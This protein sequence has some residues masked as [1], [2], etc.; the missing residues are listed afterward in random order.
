MTDTTLKIVEPNDDIAPQLIDY[1][2]FE[3][4]FFLLDDDK[5]SEE[6]VDY[7]D[8]N[9]ANSSH[10]SSDD[11]TS[12]GDDDL[13]S[14]KSDEVIVESIIR[15]FHQLPKEVKK[16]VWT[17]DE[18]FRSNI[19]EKDRL[20]IEPGKDDEVAKVTTN[21]FNDTTKKLETQSKKRKRWSE[22]FDG[23]C[24][25]AKS[26]KIVVDLINACCRPESTKL[27]L[28][29]PTL[30]IELLNE[31]KG[32]IHSIIKY[33]KLTLLELKKRAHDRH[34]STVEQ[35]EGGKTLHEFIEEGPESDLWL[36]KFPIGC[37]GQ[38]GLEIQKEILKR[39][40]VS[41]NE[42]NSFHK[43][44][45]LEHSVDTYACIY[46]PDEFEIMTEV[47]KRLL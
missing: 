30:D 1:D 12:I 38:L 39:K 41:K 16:K 40:S 28:G 24:H 3:L 35:Y 2:S 5:Q 33:F 43:K 15:K 34:N 4:D 10:E 6:H 18:V 47:I 17:E 13:S 46:R 31:K 25:A 11:V 32:Q 20:F 23:E 37:R 45:K 36:Q 21:I 27:W 9:S 7:P 19:A 26:K 14:N 22:R 29:D 42:F 44:K 8:T